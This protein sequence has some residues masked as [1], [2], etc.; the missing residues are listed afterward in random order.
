MQIFGTNPFS[1]VK[2]AH[3]SVS[4]KAMRKACGVPTRRTVY[5]CIYV[6]M[7]LGM[8]NMYVCVYCMYSM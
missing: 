5:V 2:T 3:I 1:A 8:L 6:C 7:Y 4:F